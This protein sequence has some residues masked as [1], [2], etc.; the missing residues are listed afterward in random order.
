MFT[1]Y[2]LV[3]DGLD[4]LERFEGNPIL[5]PIPGNSWESRCVFNCASVY[6]GGK[7]HIVYRA[8]GD[9]NISRLG[10]AASSDGFK[11]DERLPEPI[12]SPGHE[13]ESMGCEDPR[14][15]R[16]EQEYFM[17]YTAYG[18]MP[19][20][21]EV[22]I[23]ADDFLNK[24]WNWSRRMFPFR[25]VNNKDVVLF[26][27]K[28]KGR[29]VIYHRLHPHIWVS[30][31]EDLLHW[32]DS[33]IV[34]MPR[35]NSWEKLKLGAGAPPIKT[36]RGW[37]FI[38]H[39]VDE[40]KVYRL[41]LALVALDDPEIIIYRSREPILEPE[42]E[43]ERVG[44]VPNVVFTCGAVLKNDR[45]FVYYGGADK[46]ICVATQKLDKLLP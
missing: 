6:D 33:N 4:I 8:Q 26:P 41:G 22:T 40:A 1:E 13:F 10:Y 21:G 27:E 15:T 23:K 19:Q 25:M 11:I 38:Y 34:M 24:R 3:R 16:I 7:V 28:I 30:Y 12:F 14:I 2:L 5:E 36:R 29:W 32:K 45:L 44:D 37:L 35:G 9:D 43:F 20:V 18:D 39:S 46:V 17:F 31:S 42:T